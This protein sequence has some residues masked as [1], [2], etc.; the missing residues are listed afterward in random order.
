MDAC[1]DD[2]LADIYAIL[3]LSCPNQSARLFAATPAVLNSFSS[4]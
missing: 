1:R 4:I 2:A 3:G